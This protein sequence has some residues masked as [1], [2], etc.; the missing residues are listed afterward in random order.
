MEQI[1]FG[2]LAHV[3]AGKTTLTES[4]LYT[5]GEIEEIGR[6]DHGTAFLDT[7]A[8]EKSRGIT[9]YSKEA[10]F[11]YENRGYT[12]MD[13][14][15]HVDFSPEME[16]TLQI[17]DYA[18]LVISG[19]D[20]V[21]SH[22]ETVWRLLR[23]YSIPTFLFVNKTDL[24]EVNI[25][26]IMEELKSR[27]DSRCTN[28]S[29]AQDSPD[30]LEQVALCDESLLSQF[31]DGETLTQEDIRHGIHK[32]LIFPCHFGS[33]LK[34][35]QISE[36]LADI[37][38]YSHSTPMN[39]NKIGGKIFKI[40]RDS[41]G[42]RLTH[43]KITSGALAV[44]DTLRI[45]DYDEKITEIRLYSGKKFDFDKSVGTGTVCAVTG[46][47][48]SQAGQSFGVEKPIF[49]PSLAPVLTYTLDLPHDLEPNVALPQLKQLQEE[50]PALEILWVEEKQSIQLRIM[51]DVQLE[52][53]TSVIAERFGYE[54]AFSQRSI[55]Y[56]E[57]LAPNQ[58]LEGVG[59]YEPLRHYAEV[60][61]H[62]EGIAEGSGVVVESDCPSSVLE[63]QH[64]NLIL[65]YLREGNFRGK[66]TG[67]PLTDIKIT[68]KS[69]KAHQKH[70]VG[71]DFFEATYR[72]V[73]QGIMQGKLLLLE[74]WNKVTLKIPHDKVGRGMSDFQ[75][76]GGTCEIGQTEGDFT[77]LSGSAPIG[78]MGNYATAVASY[79]GGR[80]SCS[81]AFLGY[82]PCVDTASVVHSM[83][84]TVD[85]PR[86]SVFCK[87][88]SGFVVNWEDVPSYMHRES[89]LPKEI[90]EI[91]VAVIRQQ[92][93]QYANALAEDKDLMEIF[94]RTYGKISPEKIR[95]F[96]KKE[97]YTPKTTS[98][99]IAKKEKFLLVDG[100]NIIFAWEDLAEIARENL[101]SARQDLL[102]LLCNYQ[103]FTKEQVIVVFDAY[104][105]KG[106]VG[107][108]EPYHNITQVFTKEAETADMYIEKA[109]RSLATEYYVRVAT[110]DG[111]EQLIILGQGGHRV[112]ARGLRGE[113]DQMNRALRQFYS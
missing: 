23:K 66:L 12:L 39:N 19:S 1:V 79:T 51:G 18:I 4:L 10:R 64:Q 2:M 80:G 50:D 59:H 31:M 95:N 96:S 6:V 26:E 82:R 76:M 40:T 62:L 89:S 55:I 45:G 43:L 75:R 111:L 5:A 100:Y 28:F 78:M 97:E 105:V 56:R 9:I 24:P 67:S 92:S 104:R 15:G 85:F 53:L 109:T 54:I 22:T 57:T 90:E 86:D 41:Q 61:I 74:P 87:H 83:N 29:T 7:D 16:R 72:A 42:N 110:S 44:R 46:L 70:T 60:Q 69:G 13:T 101:D 108:V 99:S 14:P 48:H 103:G 65:S 107:T 113:I 77:H 81:L 8:L 27:L 35:E 63:Q 17:L 49:S 84:Y 47:Q 68:L 102:N 58:L 32:N 38:Q 25:D 30:F 91:P 34:L 37:H 88:G 11:T 73:G 93:R 94:Q 20:G 98:F 71:G 112:S 33:A 52:V 3:D 21:E 106:G 36:F